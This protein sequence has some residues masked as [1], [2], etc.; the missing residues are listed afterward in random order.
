VGVVVSKRF[1]CKCMFASVV[2][3]NEYVEWISSHLNYAYLFHL[4]LFRLPNQSKCTTFHNQNKMLC[5]Q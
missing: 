2:F 4:F 3:I 5:F 1:G